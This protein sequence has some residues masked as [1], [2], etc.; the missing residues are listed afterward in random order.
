MIVLQR[1][2]PIPL[3]ALH[4]TQ[5]FQGGQQRGQTLWHF[6]AKVHN[7]LE[8]DHPILYSL[9]SNDFLDYQR[10]RKQHA[11]FLS[12]QHFYFKTLL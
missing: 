6:S 4:K 8:T 7:G 9:Q 1:V 2:F 5:R 3:A 10:K 11:I 12:S